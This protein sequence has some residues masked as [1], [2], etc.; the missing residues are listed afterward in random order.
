MSRGLSQQ[1]R[2]ILGIAV[3]ANRLTQGGQVAVKTGNPVAG[4]FVPTVDYPGVKDLCWQLP[5]HLLHGLDFVEER[6]MILKSNGVWQP[7][8]PYF[9]LTTPEARSVQASVVRAITS[10]VR[11]GL[12]RWAPQTDAGGWGYVL[13]A[14]G[15]ERGLPYEMPFP[16]PLL[17]RAGMVM[18]PDVSR[19]GFHA[20]VDWLAQDRLTL[21][22]I[23]EISAHLPPDP[24]P[25][26]NSKALLDAVR[27]YVNG[28]AAGRPAHA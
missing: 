20:I 8:G 22:T 24:G 9:D 26:G 2:Q 11:T 1:Q 23:L 5:A 25:W 28:M 27:A 15:L 21:A 12:L 7:S 4:C 13:T 10:L 17:F 3:H 18:D 14:A 6:T 19:P 16:P